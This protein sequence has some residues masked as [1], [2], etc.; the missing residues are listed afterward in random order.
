MSLFHHFNFSPTS[1]KIC[2]LYSFFIT[3]QV[4]NNLDISEFLVLAMKRF[5]IKHWWAFPILLTVS[6]LTLILSSHFLYSLDWSAKVPMLILYALFFLLSFIALFVSW[7][8]LFKN[9][10]WWKVITSLLAS[11]MTICA[12]LFFLQPWLGIKAT[13]ATP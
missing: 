2:F 8:I 4:I 10:Q 6:P 1:V 11:I 13:I 12:L 9:K 7:I 5:F 3:L